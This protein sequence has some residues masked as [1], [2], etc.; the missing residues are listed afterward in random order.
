M[1]KVRILRK[2]GH[3]MQGCERDGE[4][5]IAHLPGSALCDMETLCG[6]VNTGNTYENT[7]GKVTCEGCLDVARTV[8]RSLTASE[9]KQLLK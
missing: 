1:A 9:L 8:A 5:G 4:I 2:F 3:H 6:Y 7:Q